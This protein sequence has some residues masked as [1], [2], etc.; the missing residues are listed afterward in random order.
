ML[1]IHLVVSYNGSIYYG[2]QI[3][4]DKITIQS[5]LQEVLSILNINTEL[6]FSG[7]TDKGVHA[8][9]QSVSCLIPDYWNNL[10]RLKTTLNKLLPNSIYIRSIHFVNKDF[11]A[12]FSAKKREYRYLI[13]SKK[14]TPFNSDFISY[15][16]TIDED[17]INN[18][19]KYFI[20]IND[21]EFFSKKGS[22]PISTIREIYD[23]KFYKYNDIYV[24]NFKANS[25]LRS[26]IRMMIDFIMK[27]SEGKLSIEDLK[28]QLKNKELISW[29]LAPSNGLYL[30]KIHY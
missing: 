17:K 21:F 6:E 5:T 3:Q 8:F 29:T 26:Q 4:P 18:C 27:I 15:Y 14:L 23:I 28:K 16:E 7:R 20:G 10:D 30:S 24:L 1:K 22:E 11:H 25:Y 2:S 12:R 9:R 13:S 19:I